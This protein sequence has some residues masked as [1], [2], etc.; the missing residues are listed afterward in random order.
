MPILRLVQRARPAAV[1]V[2]LTF[3]AGLATPFVPSASA[4]TTINGTT[5][6]SPTPVNQTQAVPPNIVV[7]FDDSGSMASDYMGDTPPY[8]ATK[9]W[10]SHRWYCAAVIDASS[11]SGLGGLPMNGVY[12]NPNINYTPPVY[13]DGS[14]FTAAD[15]TLLAVQ[16]DGVN[17]NR[18]LNP[19][20]SGTTNFA[21]SNKGWYLNNRGKWV[22]GIYPSG[23]GY[24][25]TQTE[26]QGAPQNSSQYTYGRYPKAWTCPGDSTNPI[27]SGPYYYRYTGPALVD[28][29]FGE[30]KNISDL[31]T[32]GNWTAVA[33]SAAQFQ[34]WANWWAYY[35]T[36]NLMARTSLS[37]VFG[38]SSLASL[39]SNGSSSSSTAYG[40]TI[41]AAWQT[42]YSTDDFTLA[43][44]TIISSLIDA[45]P[46]SC[47]AN[48]PA[49]GSQSLLSGTQKNA[50]SCYRSDFFNW[51]FQVPALNG[52]PTRSATVRAG[53]F[54]TRAGPLD[55]NHIAPGD[56]HDPYWQPPATGTSGDG[57]ELSCRQNFHMLITD[58]LWNGNKDGVGYTSLTQPS[59]GLVLPDNSVMPS[60][61]SAGVTSIYAPV[62]DS[63]DTG[64]ASL[65]D[66]AF[67][68]WATNLRSDLYAPENGE[69]VQPYLPDKSTSVFGISTL[70]GSKVSS[71]NINQ[72]IYF[73][74]KNDPATWPHMSEYMIGLGV[75]GTL[76]YSD[77]TDCTDSTNAGQDACKLRKG[78]S[79]SSGAV[80]WPVPNGYNS[81]IAANI[82]DTWHAGV[83]A[84][85][86]FFSAADPQALVDQLSKV[87]TNIQARAALPSVAGVNAS[88]L[89]AG[90]VAFTT[91]Y[92]SI[93]W[94]G[95]LAA[96]TLNADGTQ[97][98]AIWDAQS[99]LDAMTPST[100]QILT[101]S[102]K[103]DGSF[104]TGMPFEKTS[105]FD[106][107]AKT[108]LMVPA[109]SDSTNDTLATRIDYLRGEKAEE[110]NG[111]MRTRDS[112][113]GPIIDS[114]V[115]YVS[116]PN[117]G[118]TNTWPSGSPEAASGAQKYDDFVTANLHRAGTLYVGANDGMLHAFDASLKKNADGSYGPDQS[119]TAGAERWAYVP[120]AVYQNLGNLTS[121]DNFSFQQTVNGTPVSRDVFFSDQ[122]WHTL[123]VGGLRLGGRGVYA[124]DITDPTAVNE[125][126]ASSKVLW[127]F[128]AD[129]PAVSGVGTPADLGYTYGQPNIGRLANG[130]WVVIVPTGYYPDCS[131]QDKPANCQT[132]A[133]AS[134]AYSALF[135]LDAETGKMI[136][137][138]KTPTNITG[139]TSFGLTSPVLG[140]YNND[141][142]DD[143]AFAG[144]LNGNL[145]RFDFSDPN[146]SNWFVTLA[147]KPATQGAQPITVMPRLFPD[148][149]TNRFIVVYG[150]GKYLGASDTTTTSAATQSIYGIRDKLDSSGK[151]VTV[152]HGDLQVQTLSETTVTDSSDTNYGATLRS[153]TDNAVG[154]SLGGWYIDLNLTGAPG[155]RVVVTAAAD[156]STNTVIITSLIPGG[157]DLCNPTVLGAAMF[158]SATTGGP[159]TGISSLGGY[160][161]IGAR[162]NNVRTSGALPITSALGGGSSILPGL[163]LTGKKQ[164]SDK[165]I[166]SDKAIWRRR[167]WSEITGAQ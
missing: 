123:L 88:V 72:E 103:S 96:V 5:E 19:Q 24:Y 16:N 130:K 119:S 126:S 153:D 139:V 45:D 67:H 81:G 36:R 97:G 30:P 18:P 95:S 112:I 47:K 94:T 60:P 28:D 26:A 149:A 50:P 8:G 27:G 111:V 131:Q 76:N 165:P 146:P 62:H 93:D 51:I 59:G 92:S 22:Y 87:L 151:P 86:Q 74:P 141:Q 12:F 49:L 160:P 125:S 46:S 164:D 44:K 155:E 73:N 116:Y 137:E 142:I 101:S 110:T 61:G 157:N 79:N 118:Y 65:S 100:R 10:S 64:Y 107:N 17:A 152:V 55:K 144:D 29:G 32:D 66:I 132:I 39:I 35:H 114:Q 117:S 134:N 138:L 121:K 7:T 77:N 122:K 75:A 108:L 158:L 6:L 159:G 68:Y 109:S 148:P 52:T 25:S 42:L 136:A 120:R 105:T 84:R 41:R 83:A 129:A 133:A 99:K 48:E 78:Q 21:V 127:E 20:S 4:A 104:S 31:Y 34:N 85:G 14:S 163:P 38:S 82:D 80:G 135:V 69:Y 23:T 98:A 63:G 166:S 128:T 54:F 57:S 40:S 56:L 145:W 9:G 70:S 140:D 115:L 150:T 91:G 43:T 162:V 89:A 106:A 11:T 102:E 71:T 53:E 33:V 37:R 15:A 3:S 124:L 1:A 58:G 161:R 13:A 154:G 143:V 167:S 2:V 90:A 147:Y 113:L 156:F